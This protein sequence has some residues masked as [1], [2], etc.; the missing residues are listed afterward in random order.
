MSIRAGYALTLAD[1]VVAS[2]E[3]V[4]LIGH[5]DA[6]REFARQIQQRLAVRAPLVH[7]AFFLRHIVLIELAGC[8]T[9]A[10][11][12]GIASLARRH[13]A[14]QT[15]FRLD[16][17]ILVRLVKTLVVLVLVQ[18]VHD[19]RPERQRRIRLERRQAIALVVTKPAHADIVWR[20][21]RKPA[22][23]VI[24]CRTGLACDIHAVNGGE[25]AGAV[26]HNIGQQIVDI[27]RGELRM[28][29]NLCRLIV[30]IGQNRLAVC[31]HDLGVADGGGILSIIRQSRIALCH[32]AHGHAVGQAA[33]R[34]RRI[35]NIALAQR[36]KAQLFRQEIIRGLRRQLI[37]DTDRNG[38]GGI[39]NRLHNCRLTGVGAVFVARPR[40]AVVVEHRHIRQHGIRGNQSLIQRRRIGRQ[41]LERGTR[42][43]LGLRCAVEHQTLGLFAAAA[44]NAE[45]MSGFRVD[46]HHRRL[47]L[48]AVLRNAREVAAVFKYA[49][50]RVLYVLIHSRIDGQSAA[51]HER[52]R[53]GLGVAELALQIVNNVRD[54]HVGKVR[55]RLFLLLSRRIFV[56]LQLLVNRLIVFALGNIALLVHLIQHGLLP[57]LGG[58]RILKRIVCR[59]ILRQARNQGTLR[60]I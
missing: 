43:T 4:I 3:A 33:Q 25:L 49:F 15:V 54:D 35:V 7:R 41:R 39:R 56:I 55:V 20:V 58:V 46:N 60:E 42:R 18:L 38:V 22:V 37:H 36:G 32:F 14:V 2:A 11:H 50:H 6:N 24:G 45:N 48:D 17:I 47:R 26:F 5:R 57:L 27:V 34:H 44:H 8:H 10:A 51:R 12:I 13:A 1:R 23:L 30:L 40:L 19:V 28:L 59:R 53:I 52:P 16:K 29:E 21:A 31:V 9:A